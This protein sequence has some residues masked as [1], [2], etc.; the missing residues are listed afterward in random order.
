MGTTKYIILNCFLFSS[1]SPGLNQ[2]SKIK[3][4]TL[5]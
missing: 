1:Y 2:K 3:V 5:N 4:E